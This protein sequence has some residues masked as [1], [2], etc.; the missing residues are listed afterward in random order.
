MDPLEYADGMNYF[1]Y[2]GCSPTN[3]KDWDGKKSTRTKIIDA[4]E[5]T[6]NDARGAYKNF[7]TIKEEIEI[8]IQLKKYIV[9][10]D[11]DARDYLIVK[12][13]TKTVKRALTK[14]GLPGVLIKS[15][16]IG[17]ANGNWLGQN[18]AKSILDSQNNGRCEDCKAWVPCHDRIYRV[19]ASRPGACA[20]SHLCRK[21]GKYIF[22]D[23]VIK[24]ETGLFR[25][26]FNFVAGANENNFKHTWVLCN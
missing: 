18:M 20:K 25:H 17:I 7:K 8:A 24:T 13:L 22:A 5:N 10:G 19:D 2:A 9:D 21:D 26:L 6:I 1:A 3:L 4:L 15:A 11:P 23:V 12:G 16:E 14:L